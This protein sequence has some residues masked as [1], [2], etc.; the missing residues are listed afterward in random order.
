MQIKRH[1]PININTH[2]NISSSYNQTM[3][4]FEEILNGRLGISTR[5]K[6]NFALMQ[7]KVENN[8]KVG[9]TTDNVLHNTGNSVAKINKKLENTPMAGLGKT[10]KAAE[11]HTGISAYVLASIAIHESAYGKSSIARDKANLFG[12]KAYDDN[13]Y[14]SAKAYHSFDESIVDVAEYLKKEYLSVGGKHFNG[15]GLD[16]IG[17]KYATDPAWSKKVKKILDDFNS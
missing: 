13:P 8:N 4:R 2:T 6:N 15:F 7:Q 17:K 16:D 10:F 1:F 3:A 5:S 14:S 9:F 11:N 12:F